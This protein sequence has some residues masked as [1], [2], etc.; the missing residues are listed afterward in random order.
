MGVSQGM[1]EEFVHKILRNLTLVGMI[2]LASMLS[3]CTIPKLTLNS[4]DLY[5]LPT[6]PA[7]YTELN[8]QL[9]EILESGAEYA[10]PTSGANI[11]SVQLVDLDGD[12]REEAVAFF[13]NAAEEKPLKIYIFTATEDSYQKTELIEGSGTGIY[14]IAYT[15]LDGDGRMELLVGWKATT[16]L[17]VLEVYALRPGGAALLVRSDYV[18]YTAMDLDQDQ[19]QELVVLHADEGGDGVADYYSWQEDGS[20]ASQS[21][22]RLS[23]TMA[24]LN[25]QGRVTQGKLQEEVPALFVTGVTD[26][27][28]A[29]TDILSVRNGELT[30]VVLSDLTG[31]SGEIA[32]FCSLYPSDINN[33]G[34]TEVPSPIQVSSMMETGAAYQRVDWY[35]YNAGGQS[36]LALHTYHDVEDRWYLRLPEE[37]LN[38]IW[39]GRAT[40]PDEAAVTFYILDGEAMEPFLRITAIT[41]SSRENRAV[42]GGRFLLSRQSEV[43]YTAELLDAND[44]WQY[45]VTADE[46]REAFS[47]IT[48]EWSAGDY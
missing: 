21:S 48:S 25:Q 47:L 30:N 26:A 5:S 13:R 20:L 19:R 2:F 1:E 22:A 9:N 15:D 44:T 16:E 41:G 29:V 17:Q 38:H 24:E 31:V 35:A 7:K 18:K 14:S 42:R 8:T 27:S 12:G 6:L 43:I 37:W 34:L 39:V 3:G 11:Q 28:R 32:P 4:E 40:M 10:A 23:V 45:G 36:N 33:D 46:V